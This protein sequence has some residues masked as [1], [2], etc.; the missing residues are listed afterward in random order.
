KKIDNETS[1]YYV[2]G[3]YTSNPDPT[4]RTRKLEVKVRR[5]GVQVWSRTSYS[6]KPPPRPATK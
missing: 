4:R 1:D 5:P 2:L 6:L 3:Y